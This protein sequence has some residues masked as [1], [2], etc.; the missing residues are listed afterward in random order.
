MQLNQEVYLLLISAYVGAL[1]GILSLVAEVEQIEVN[2]CEGI[3]VYNS[4]DYQPCSSIT[5][6][7]SISW[8][9]LWGSQD[10]KPHGR[11]TIDVIFLNQLMER[12]MF[13]P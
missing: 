5:M 2:V 1:M 10:I 7:F 3:V 8:S 4:C 12:K 9:S 11:S 6:P 13:L